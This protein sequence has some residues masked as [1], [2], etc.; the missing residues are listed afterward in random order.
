M[1][2]VAYNNDA[3][4]VSSGCKSMTVLTE[5]KYSTIVRLVDLL[6]VAVFKPLAA[7]PRG[8][9]RGYVDDD[10]VREPEAYDG[11]R[12]DLNLLTLCDGICTCTHTTAGCGSDGCSLAAAQDAAQDCTHCS[13]TADLFRRVLA[14][15]FAFL[16]V[17][18][19]CD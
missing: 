4:S 17:G 8:A 5:I 13:A 9:A 19:S 11:L 1:F 15:A 10:C 7:V 14:A 6:V 2:S 18:V 3:V 16:G 12:L